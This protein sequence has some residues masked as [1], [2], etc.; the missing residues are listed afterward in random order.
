MRNIKQVEVDFLT[1]IRWLTCIYCVCTLILAPHTSFLKNFVKISS[2][3]NMWFPSCCAGKIPG[4]RTRHQRQQL[5]KLL[6]A[7]CLQ[8]EMY[9]YSTDSVW[10]FIHFSHKLKKC[11][12][13]FKICYKS[14]VFCPIK[15]QIANLTMFFK[16]WVL[17]P[18]TYMHHYCTLKKHWRVESLINCCIFCR[19][20]QDTRFKYPSLK[21]NLRLYYIIYYL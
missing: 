8:C 15:T 6:S 12:S 3:Y 2:F 18:V 20:L 21:M 1:Y 13:T 17:F 16:I 4:W 7:T 9:T 11:K 19:S 10:I 14:I 5:W